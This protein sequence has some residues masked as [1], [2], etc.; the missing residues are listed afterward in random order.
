MKVKRFVHYTEKEIDLKDMC[1]GFL[2]RAL[3]ETKTN[4]YVIT[5]FG[6]STIF[7]RGK[8]FVVK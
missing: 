5:S 2:E 6:D 1:T 3:E 4:Q 8:K 7:Y